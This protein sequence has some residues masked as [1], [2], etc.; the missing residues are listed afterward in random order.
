V[1]GEHA[2]VVRQFYDAVEAG[3]LDE[4]ARLLDPDVVAVSPQGD[5]ERG[6]AAVIASLREGLADSHVQ[7]QLIL[8]DAE[9]VAG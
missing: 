1:A 5:P 6:G 9:E 2:S 7:T 8:G 3:N 4:A